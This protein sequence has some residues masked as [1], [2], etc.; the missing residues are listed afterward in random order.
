MIA[1][2][3]ARETKIASTLSLI[4]GVAWQPHINTTLTRGNLRE[5]EAFKKLMFELSQ[6]EGG[7][8]S[9]IPPDLSCL[10]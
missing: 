5:Y 4:H 10:S 1:R 6:S 2:R 3:S 7:V 9:G 8:Q